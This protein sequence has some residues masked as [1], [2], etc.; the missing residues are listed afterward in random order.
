[1]ATSVY[2]INKGINRSIEFK[3]L[4][5]QYIW[6]LAAGI[7]G[8]MLICAA[9]LLIGFNQYLCIAIVLGTG[10][11]LVFKVYAMSAKYGEYGLMKKIA[12]KSIPKVVKVQSRR[13]FIYKGGISDGENITN[14]GH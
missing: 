10:T 8:L 9:L 12:R 7:V 1:M 5:A 11:A 4:R 3:G 13:I 2:I 14:A 6:Y